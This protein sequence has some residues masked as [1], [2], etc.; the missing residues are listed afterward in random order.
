MFI[1]KSTE[2]PSALLGG[3]MK[4]ATSVLWGGGV[5]MPPSLLGGYSLDLSYLNKKKALKRVFDKVTA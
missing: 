1:K 5:Q 3:G 2:Y 4:V